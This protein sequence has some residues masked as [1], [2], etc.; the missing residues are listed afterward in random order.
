MWTLLL[1][2]SYIYGLLDPNNLEIRY[3]GKSIDPERRLKEHVRSTRR[4]DRTPRADWMKKLLNQTPSIIILERVHLSDAN[5]REKFWIAFMRKQGARLLNLTEGGDGWQVGRHFTF[6]H[7]NK[8]SLANL[9]SKRTQQQIENIKTSCTDEWRRKRRETKITNKK[10]N[11]ISGYI[12]VSKFNQNNKW[13]AYLQIENRQ[14][15]F[16]Y[17]D[18][19]AEAGKAYNENVVLY[20]PDAALN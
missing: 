20:Y 19:A 2:N 4:G 14:L 7:R 10:P 9:G 5:E 15:H 17:Y 1:P 6:Q 16:G 12:G 18:T 3:V 8:I 13:R 11:K